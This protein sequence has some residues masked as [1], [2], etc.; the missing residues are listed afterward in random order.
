[1]AHDINGDL[2]AHTGAASDDDDLLGIEVHSET[3][4]LIILGDSCLAIS[5][6]ARQ[7][8]L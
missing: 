3:L 4:L 6:F 1:V 5:A 8:E 2:P 7:E